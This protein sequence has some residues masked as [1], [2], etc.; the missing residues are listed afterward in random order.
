MQI[1]E[2]LFVAYCQC[3]Y[4]A[5]LKSKGEVGE[6]VDY[7]V[8][9]KE[10]DARFKEH[11][12][13]RLL[14]NHVESQISREPAS[15]RLAAK[16]GARLIIGARVEAQGVALR[17][18]AV[19]R[20]VDRDD[21]KRSVYVPVCFSHKYKLT[22]ED[23][24]LATLHGIILA[25]ALGQPVPFVKVVHGPDFAVSKIK[26]NAPRGTPRL[27]KDARQALDR[28]RKQIECTSPPFMILNDHC[29][30]CEFRDRCHAEAVRKDDLSLMRGMSEKEILA[31]RK[32]GINTVAQFACTFHPKSVGAKRKNPLKRHLHALQALA[33]RD[34]KVYVVR[35]PEI[36]AKATRV[37]LDV[38]GMPDRDFYYLV[39]VIVEADG[40]CSTHS[41]WADDETEEQAI[42]FK[43]LDLLRVL[44]ECTIFH[45]GAYEQA[46]VKKMLRRYPSPDTPFPGTLDSALFNVLGAIRTNVYFPA[47][48]N[49]LKDIASY[50]GVNWT[51]K[52]KSGIDCIAA[53]MRWEQ[54][55]DPAIKEEIHDY[56]R[57]DC[58]AVQHVASFLL[59]LGSPD[60]TA[61]SQ[62]QLASRIE[63]ESHGRFGTI[64]FAVPEMGFINRCARFNYQRYKVLF[65]TDPAVRA[66][67]RRKQSEAR[68]IRRANL[69]IRCDPSVHCPD[70]GATQVTLLR[71]KSH[72]KLIY[73][74]RFT[75][76]GV[77]RCVIRYYSQRSQCQRCGKT[78]YSDRYPKEQK[79]G[80]A[81]ES[82]AVYQHVAL[83]Q[84]FA[85]IALS[86]N[87]IFGYCYSG[88]IGQR[89]Q[90]RLAEV[91]RVTVEKMLNLLRSGML[92]HA[93]ETK[94]SIKGGGLGYV[95]AFTSKRDRCLPLS[96][97]QGRNHPE[98]N[99]WRLRWGARLGLLLCL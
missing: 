96:S 86:I 57:Q 32:R 55:K 68:P 18:N 46:Y 90:T 89:A 34:K 99:P 13:D 88:G 63:V 71:S 70:C 1:T 28:L 92:I 64:D 91:Y 47:Y 14:K 29:P 73:D 95:W 56:N 10:A 12:I 75:Q 94:I 54:L 77:K 61:T 81:L 98:R 5:F 97:D 9:Q 66:S 37:F 41:Y 7:E 78:F 38:E 45:Y 79:T 82:W 43:L 24:L 85:D 87:D 26:M 39:G 19:E 50:L 83:R 76:T 17:F 44:D 4:K 27:V 30:T 22:R 62:V 53:R 21:D 15:L 11:A 16:E 23:S 49:G 33:V 74:L 72:S 2:G 80:H 51:G 3:P 93:D 6:V 58:L 42:W 25:E 48:S 59:S 52:V 60:G 31:Q 65:R 35:A 84:S 36:P 8:I 20:L 40:Q 67:I 69:E